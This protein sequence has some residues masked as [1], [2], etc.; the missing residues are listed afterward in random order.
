MNLDKRKQVYE[1]VRVQVFTPAKVCIQAWNQTIEQ[2]YDP[3]YDQVVNQFRK[4][5]QEAKNEPK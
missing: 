3:G 5:V 1:Q 2:V 4:Q